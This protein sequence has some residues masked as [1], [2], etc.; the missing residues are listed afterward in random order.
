MELIDAIRER[1]SVRKYREE[2]VP[3][4]V[5]EQVLEAACWAPSADNRQPWYF[6]A[7]TKPEDIALLR[8]TAEKVA[9]EIRPHLEEMFPRHP[10]VVNETTAFLRRLGGA[11]VY[12]LVFL[13]EDY[14]LVR[15]S[16]LESA[17]AAIQNLL[18]AAHEKGLGTCWVNAVT[19]LGYGPALQQAF[20]PD[21]GEFVSLVTLGYADHTPRA[22]GRKPGRWVIR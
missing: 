17:A 4:E 12:V 15:D 2:P 7:L 11:P 21:Q 18:L 13:Q 9:E 3:R 16:M 6:V 5:L 20:A 19:G 10:R 22:P 8:E 14:G 1:R